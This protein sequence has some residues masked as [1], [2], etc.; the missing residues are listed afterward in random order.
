MAAIAQFVERWV[1][2]LK[3]LIPGFIPKLAMRRCVLGKA[4][5]A[6]IPL[7]VKQS[8]TRVGGPA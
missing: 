8:Y 4:L 7:G 3:M 1:S 6:Y 5:Y 2:D